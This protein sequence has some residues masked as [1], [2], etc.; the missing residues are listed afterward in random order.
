[1]PTFNIDQIAQEIKIAQDNALALTPFTTRYLDFD[2]SDAYQVARR[3]HDLRTNEGSRPVGRKIGFTNPE[4][5]QIF[6]VQEPVWA[7]VYDDTVIESADGN[8]QLDIGRFHSPRI[9]PE[10]VVHF[11]AAPPAGATLDQ[12]LACIDWLAHGIEIV[13]SHFPDWKFQAADTVADWG[14][15]AALIVGKQ[16]PIAQLT[17]D[18][19]PSLE[20]FSV[21]LSCNGKLK[22]TGFGRNVLGSPLAAVKHLLKVLSTQADA[23]P[24]QAGELI[25][26][27]TLTKAYPIAPGETWS[28]RIEGLPL[29]GFRI[30][31]SRSD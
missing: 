11:R 5:W 15:H 12:T 18:L 31:L 24:I 7:Y 9:E 22:E 21:D 2:M 25:T 16:L 3:V 20:N 10:I 1:M 29:P 8:V 4:M 27:G 30:T 14:L 19:A 28:T 13:Q 23:E 17:H 26:T 6:G